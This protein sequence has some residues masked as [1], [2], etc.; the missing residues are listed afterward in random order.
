MP[1]CKVRACR[2]KATHTTAGHRCGSC[3]MYGHG[4][5]ECGNGDAVRKLRASFLQTERVDDPCT[6]EGC[7]HAWTHVV[8]AHHCGRC[9]ERGGGCGCEREEEQKKCPHCRLVS[10]VD[11]ERPVHTGSE[12]CVCMDVKPCVVFEACRHA[13]VCVDCALRL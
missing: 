13:T 11:V 4:I 9:G 2:F 12:C 10:R 7:T 6:V 3:G 5:L 8:E 1:E